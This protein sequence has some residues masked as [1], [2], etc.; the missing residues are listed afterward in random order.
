M[1]Y[2]LLVMIIT[3]MYATTGATFH[4]DIASTITNLGIM[5]LILVAIFMDLLEKLGRFL[6]VR[7]CLYESTLKLLLY[8]VCALFSLTALIPLFIF[9]N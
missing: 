5:G 6:C 4:N 8:V 3:L 9:A 1:R 7:F 2:S